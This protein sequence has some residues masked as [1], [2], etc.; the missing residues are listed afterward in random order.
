MHPQSFAIICSFFFI[1]C[2]SIYHYIKMIESPKSDSF[3][4]I[5]YLT[6]LFTST[7]YQK[8]PHRP[9]LRVF[10]YLFMQFLFSSDT[11]LE[12]TEVGWWKETNSVTSSTNV[13]FLRR[14]F[15]RIEFGNVPETHLVFKEKKITN[16]V[17][18]QKKKKWL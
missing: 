9:L 14:L 2:I 4:F 6:F 11:F 16:L 7:H 8:S 10:I 15:V 17:L 1:Y 12:N 3:L 13:F 18:Y 5:N